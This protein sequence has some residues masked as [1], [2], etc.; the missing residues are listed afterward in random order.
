MKVMY[1][2]EKT[3]FMLCD[4]FSWLTTY[5]NKNLHQNLPIFVTLLNQIKIFEMLKFLVQRKSTKLYKI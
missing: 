1:G 5:S 4:I 3:K 2:N